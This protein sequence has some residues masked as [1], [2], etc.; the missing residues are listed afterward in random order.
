[1]ASGAS[2]EPQGGSLLR[3][4]APSSTFIPT[5]ESGRSEGGEERRTRRQERKQY[6]SEAGGGVSKIQPPNL[7]KITACSDL[8]EADVVA[9]TV[10][11]DQLSADAYVHVVACDMHVAC[12]VLVVAAS[13]TSAL[14]AEA[15]APGPASASFA[16]TPAVGAAI[17]ASV[18]S[19]FAF[20]LQ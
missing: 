9:E 2:V 3:D 20:Y 6:F 1:M 14:A 15:P 13:A 12:A 16:V 7:I 8:H 11:L 19:F 17:G 5:A 4:G 10:L 18:L